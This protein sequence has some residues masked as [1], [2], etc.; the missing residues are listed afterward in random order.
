MKNTK[1]LFTRKFKEDI[2]NLK[3][4]QLDTDSIIDIDNSE[5]KHALVI[6][7]MITS[8]IMKAE[9]ASYEASKAGDSE[10]TEETSETAT[11]TD[12]I[13]FD[14]VASSGVVREVA[15]RIFKELPKELD[16]QGREKIVTVGG[17]IERS[18]KPNKFSKI[19]KKDK[20]LMASLYGETPVLREVPKS[21]K[22]IGY[23][24]IDGDTYLGVIKRKVP[25]IPIILF[26]L[27]VGAMCVYMA[28]PEQRVPISL[29]NFITGPVDQGDID[30]SSKVE[31]QKA[32]NLRIIMNVSPTLI[33]GQMNLMI[34][35]NKE[36]NTLSMVAD[37][38]LLSEIDSKGNV[39]ETYKKP[40]V[41]AQTPLLHPGDKMEQ[42]PVYEDAEVKPGI[43]DGRVM[44]T[45]YKI[46]E[47]GALPIGQVAGRI[48]LVVK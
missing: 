28:L 22:V 18:T 12:N 21:H 1:K 10:I 5:E 42:V 46:T 20:K 17:Y 3:E 4:L 40:I 6:E 26:G 11:N 2:S 44:Y 47:E 14:E 9:N 41:I 48:T 8:E 38:M 16:E 32:Q 35:N 24:K 39:I 36:S 19:K 43:Y 23:V 7:Q 45:A 15:Y 25:F 29:D 27:I 13:N 37:V 30:I 34:S 33:D 31:L